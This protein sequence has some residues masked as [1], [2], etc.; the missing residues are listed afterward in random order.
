[1]QKYFIRRFPKQSTSCRQHKSKISNKSEQFEETTR[2][3]NAVQNVELVSYFLFQ[4]MKA[5]L[6]YVICG[7]IIKSPGMRNE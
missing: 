1:M 7:R 5:K 6:E 4:L 3:A 2:T